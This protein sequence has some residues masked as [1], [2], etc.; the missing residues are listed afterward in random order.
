MKSVIINGKKISAKGEIRSKITPMTAFLLTLFV[1][2]C[3]IMFV[4]LGWAFLSSFR[5]PDM[6]VYYPHVWTSPNPDD[7]VGWIGLAN[8]ASIIEV[9]PV[10]TNTIS[11]AAR[12]TFFGIILNSALYAFGCAFLKTLVPCLTAYICARYKFKFSKIV[13]AT[14]IV[15]MTIPVIGSLPSE[16]TF[17]MAFGFYNHIWGLWVMHANFLGMYFLVFYEMFDSL[18]F[19]YYEAA[20]I[21]GASDF[22][23]MIH[24]GLPLCRN[25]FMTVMLIN[26]ITYWNDY[27]IPLLYLPQKVTI[28]RYLYFFSNVN[29]IS[30]DPAM[31]GKY[32]GRLGALPFQ[33]T[34]AVFMVLPTVI[35]FCIFQKRLL[36]NLTIGGIKG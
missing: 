9:V 18:P 33:I 16:L 14:A 31:E 24:I 2:Y 27:Q 21:D 23:Q 11:T 7:F 8:Y 32:G 1:V 4:L 36:G 28:A 20:S 10:V 5:D 12:E 19:T 15:V 17:A 29:R 25:T 34:A 6:F 22:Q 35:L 13:Y 26:F 30:G 3:I